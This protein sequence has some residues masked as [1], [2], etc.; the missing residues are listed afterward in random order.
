ML[1]PCRWQSPHDVL[2]LVRV[3]FSKPKFQRISACRAGY[4]HKAWKFESDW[5]FPPESLRN[6]K[7][8]IAWKENN[9]EWKSSKNPSPA[10]VVWNS[11]HSSVLPS[12]KD[13]S[14]LLPQPRRNSLTHHWRVHS[15][16]FESRQPEKKICPLALSVIPWFSSVCWI[17]FLLV[18]PLWS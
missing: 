8:V 14:A 4:C 13:M 2:S 3:Q 18:L 6:E 15:M 7:L 17:F 5:K 11:P 12:P 16:L 1:H 10:K 9:A